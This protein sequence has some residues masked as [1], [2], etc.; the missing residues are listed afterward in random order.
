[1]IGEILATNGE[2]ITNAVIGYG[3]LVISA[4]KL[5][6]SIYFAINM[7]HATRILACHHGQRVFIRIEEHLLHFMMQ[8]WI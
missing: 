1:M 2:E 5:S 4:L 3:V 6:F 8:F 7:L